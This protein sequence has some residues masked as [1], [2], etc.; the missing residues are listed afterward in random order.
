MQQ[1]NIYQGLKQEFRK[2]GYYQRMT[3]NQTTE[4]LEH[5]IPTAVHAP[6]VYYT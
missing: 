4:A 5:A 2:K 1:P 3:G 6:Y